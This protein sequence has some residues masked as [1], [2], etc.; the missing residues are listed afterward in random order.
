MK[1][2][3]GLLIPFVAAV[4]ASCSTPQVALEQA[5]NSV[6]LIQ[7]L[8]TELSTYQANVKLL[9]QR[10]MTSIERLY[11]TTSNLVRSQQFDVYLSGKA[12][13]SSEL[14][15]RERLRDASDTYSKLIAAEDKSQE[16]LAARLATL[17][18]GLPTP[19][20]KLGAVQKA[21]AELG[22]ELSAKE[23]VAIVTKFLKQAK[24]IVNQG[25]ASAA[26]PAASAAAAAA[27]ASAAS[28]P[29][30]CTSTPEKEET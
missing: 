22:T 3:L 28:S 9:A 7:N 8:Q 16:Q 14:E 12:G 17:V 15:A 1:L 18:K 5:N 10:R 27:P 30:S 26:A 4:L 13:L 29:A 6:R 20:D 24:C 25:A 19:S 23:R 21:M 2:H 11:A